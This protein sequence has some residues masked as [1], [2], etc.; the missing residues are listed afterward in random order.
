MEINLSNDD[1]LPTIKAALPMLAGKGGG[2]A[3]IDP[4]EV[5]AVFKDVKQLEMIQVDVNKAGVTE[6]DVIS[7]YAGHLPSGQWDQVFWQSIPGKGTIAV[8]VHNQGESIYGFRVRTVTFDNKPIE[9]IEVA[10][11]SGKIDFARLVAMGSKVLGI[12]Q[13]K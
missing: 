6:K 9:R 2:F 3:S 12:H 8:Y 11:S 4:D 13:D 10:K 5:A 1:I 7:Y